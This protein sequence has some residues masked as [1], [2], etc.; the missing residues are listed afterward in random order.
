MFSQTNALEITMARKGERGGEKE[1]VRRERIHS[2]LTHLHEN[3]IGKC[4]HY[5][6]LRP[7]HID[8]KTHCIEDNKITTAR[9]KV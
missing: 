4:V 9:L 2:F 1:K 8:A 3:S 6:S 7:M 5:I